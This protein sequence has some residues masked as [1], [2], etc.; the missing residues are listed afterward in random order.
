MRYTYKSVVLS[1][2]VLM[3]LS[4]LPVFAVTELD[5]RTLVKDSSAFAFDLYQALCASDSNIFLSPYSISTALAM[6]YAG[7]R[8]NTEKQMA[9]TLRFS[10][11]QKHLHPAFAE[12]ESKLNKLQ[13]CSRVQLSIANSLWP[14]RDYKFLNEYLYLI[15]HYYGIS[16]TPVDYNLN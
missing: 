7:A 16:I 2:V 1:V 10:L 6:K 11:D 15:K 8:G 14:Q 3:A 12:F 9:R 5:V 13:K 4:R